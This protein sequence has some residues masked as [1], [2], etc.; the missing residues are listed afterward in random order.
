DPPLRRPLLRRPRQRRPRHHRQAAPRRRPH[1][2]HPPHLTEG[3]GALVDTG[4]R[5]T[6]WTTFADGSKE[7][8]VESGPDMFVQIPAYRDAELPATLRSLYAKASRPERLRVRV[9]WQ[10]APGETLPGDV[11]ALP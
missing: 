8:G 2:H 7:G 11:M 5:V 3:G 9:L 1:R 6:S 10:H 4:P